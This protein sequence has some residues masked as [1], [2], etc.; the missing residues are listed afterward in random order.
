MGSHCG[1][2]AAVHGGLPENHR[3]GRQELCP[4]VDAVHVSCLVSCVGARLIGRIVVQLVLQ[5]IFPIFSV[6]FF[7]LREQTGRLC[8]VQPLFNKLTPLPAGEIRERVERLSNKLGFPLTHL[9]QIDGS[10]R[11]SHSNA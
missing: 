11:S 5:I 1:H 7:A 4:L 6:S 10:K 3:D 2:W 9:Y 8:P